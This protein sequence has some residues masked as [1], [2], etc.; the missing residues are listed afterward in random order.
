[1]VG[2]SLVLPFLLLLRTQ[3]PDSVLVTASA[4]L[5]SQRLADALRSYLDE[6]GI[7]VA[8]AAAESSADLRKQLAEERRLG[9]AVRAVAVVR[10][11]RFTPGTIEIEIMDLATEKALVATVPRP[12]RDEDLYRALALKIQAILRSTFS[13]GRAQMEPGSGVGR[14]LSEG[15]RGA[16]GPRTPSSSLPQVGSTEDSGGLAEHERVPTRLA[17]ETGYLALAFPIGG[18]AFQGLAA[19]VIARV[20]RRLDLTFGSAVLSSIRAEGGGVD[21]V[22]TIVPLS[23]SARVHFARE[24]AELLFGPTAQAALVSVSPSSATVRVRPTRSL[25][26]AFGVEAEGR[27]VFWDATWLFARGQALGVLSG[28]RYDVAGSPIL[29][30]SRFEI[31]AT[32]GVGVGFR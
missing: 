5:D 18:P 13:E 9:E 6:Y 30:T 27:L 11:E 2:S 14:F 1:V 26:S 15:R 4:P 24:R 10:A 12:V 7:R 17:I 21:A 25:I 20:G 16:G 22:A 3:M 31:M 29:D 8:V 32:I 19:T 28:Q 23:V